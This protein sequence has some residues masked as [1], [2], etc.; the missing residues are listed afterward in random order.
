MTTHNHAKC[1]IRLVTCS[2]T[3]F[4]VKA[5]IISLEGGFVRMFCFLP[6][7]WKE[8]HTEKTPYGFIP[9]CVCMGDSLH[10]PQ[11]AGSDFLCNILTLCIWQNKQ[12]PRQPLTLH[13][14]TLATAWKVGTFK[15]CAVLQ[16][17]PPLAF[18]LPLLTQ[19]WQRHFSSGDLEK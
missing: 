5:L 17:V 10:A 13:F 3:G 9:W 16:W 14:G 11:L 8:K 19:K 7:Y 2:D 4:R 15:I 1:L 18:T 12:V 6:S